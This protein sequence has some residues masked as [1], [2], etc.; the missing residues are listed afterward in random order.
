MQ[1]LDCKISSKI[2][3]NNL[4]EK[5]YQFL[6]EQIING[7]VISGTHLTDLGLSVSLGISRTPV[8][9]ALNKLVKDGLVEFV[10]RKGFYVNHLFS[11]DV[12]EIYELR[13]IL[14]TYGLKKSINNIPE[15]EIDNLINLFNEAI[16][17]S[18]ENNFDLAIQAD[19]K[20]HG[21]IIKYAGN[22]L[23]L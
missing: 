3:H 19:R 10:P 14:E 9:E 20:L 4:S 8:R 17:E 21:I 18:K 7:V 5:S 6:A 13:E 15:K 16:E 12:N 22:F 1:I 23:G 2:E 11:E